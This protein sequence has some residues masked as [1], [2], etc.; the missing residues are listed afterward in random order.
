MRRRMK[1]EKHVE[2]GPFES[3]GEWVRQI[4]LRWRLALV[5]FALLAVLL[6]ALG[7]LISFTEERA[8]IT[9]EAAALYNEGRLAAPDHVTSTDLLIHRLAGANTGASI[10]LPDGTDVTP[11]SSDLVGPVAPAPV[12]ISASDLQ[13]ALN[14]QAPDSYTYLIE[15]DTTG[16]R[17]LVVLFRVYI[18]S[19]GSTTQTAAVLVLHTL[20]APIDHAV[21]A[22]R[23]ILSIGILVALAIAAAL[24]LPLVNTALRPLRAMEQASRRIADGALSLRLEP[25]PTQDEIGRLALS[26]NVMV[27]RLEEMFARQKRF[28]AD[29]A[30][31]LRTPLTALGGGLEMLLMGAD[32]GDVE[33]SRRLMR[34]MY[35]ETERM[36]R[37]VEDL[38]TLTRID[39]G[40]I[41]LRLERIEVEPLI[42]D[43]TEQAR[44]LAHGQEVSCT[45]ADGLPPMRADAD[46]IRQVLLNLVEN[47]L[48][49]T[50]APGQVDLMARPAKDSLGGGV[51]LEVH[52]TGAGIPA[53]ALPHVFDRFYRA[54]PARARRGTQQGG[55]GLGLAIAKSL[56][57][58]QGGTISIASKEGAGTTLTIVLPA[59][60]E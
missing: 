10:L 44:Q 2:R 11:S 30:H 14:D 32:R 21:A 53:E 24:I 4:P 28:V 36:R 42:E 7:A 20:T 25:P 35:A 8:L 19:P 33:A 34:G 12:T 38:L 49:F 13:R 57:E 40:R 58:A 3:L 54:D 41:A 52:D 26:F 59:W 1:S 48:K 60:R 37:L 31:E 18:S 55:S 46:R 39:E 16:H 5:S 23:F 43:V 50:P 51:A 6:G 27:A 17:Q 56:V 22:T 47:A 29:A 15:N 9:N 45:V